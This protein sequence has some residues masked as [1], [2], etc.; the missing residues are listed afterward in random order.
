MIPILLSRR[1]RNEVREWLSLAEDVRD[2]VRSIVD[3]LK[4]DNPDR[5]REILETRIREQ[6]AGRAA[7]EASRLAGARK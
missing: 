1:T 2:F 4:G 7:H 5:A 3:A 6:A